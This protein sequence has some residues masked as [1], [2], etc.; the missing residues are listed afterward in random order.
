MRHWSVMSRS[1]GEGVGPVRLHGATRGRRDLEACGATVRSTVST[2]EAP[3]LPPEF[4]GDNPRNSPLKPERPNAVESPQLVSSRMARCT[5]A[6]MNGLEKGDWQSGGQICLPLLTPNYS[7]R[8]RPTRLT[9]DSLQENKQTDSKCRSQ[10]RSQH[11]HHE[12]LRDHHTTPQQDSY[13]TGRHRA[14]P[15]P[16]SKEPSTFLWKTP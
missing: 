10:Q 9:L 12:R 8:R 14:E 5:L 13:G 1:Y 4:S 3:V 6:S 15:L 2:P 7:W 16:P 11:H